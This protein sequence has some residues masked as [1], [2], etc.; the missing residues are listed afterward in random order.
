MK[1][2]KNYIKKSTYDPNGSSFM[3]QSILHIIL[4]LFS[5]ACIIPFIFSIIISL[6]DELALAKNGYSFFPEIMSVD[7]YN[8]IL[9]NGEML[10]NSYLVSIFVTLVGT[11]LALFVTSMY[12]YVLF[13]KE[14][15]FRKFFTFY[16]FFTM[17]FGGGLVPF[18]I[19]MTQFLN[20]R[21]S[22]WALV[23]PGML[24]AF[25][26]IILRTFFTSS[27]HTAL[28]DA[29]KIDGCGEFKTFRLIVLPLCLP[30]IAT[31]GLF[32]ALFYWNDWFNAL[33]FIDNPNLIPL[34]YLLMRIQ[35]NMDFV[36]QNARRLTASQASDALASLP[37]ESA[38]MVM[39]VLVV[40]PIACAYPFFQKYFI[41]GLT[42]GGV[43][44]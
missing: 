3:Q 15:R 5:I 8:Y 40:L 6:T 38:R 37:R 42:I 34:Q 13:R 39:V 14:Y 1:S 36:I 30:G 22:I 24:S 28:I 27:V 32:S 41:K 33:L 21:D 7:A 25:N 19:T 43:K 17:I 4:F 11:I 18:Y 35:N 20:L 29:T 12:A 10:G 16:A 2:K 44:G 31:I 26:I 23:V 9:K